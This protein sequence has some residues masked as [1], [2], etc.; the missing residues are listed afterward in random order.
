MEENLNNPVETEPAQ[1]PPAAPAAPWQGNYTPP[2][3]LVFPM[4]RK[5]LLFA[6]GILI[7]SMMLCNSLYCGGVNLGVGVAVLGLLG[8]S[9]VYLLSCGHKPDRYTGCMLILCAVI[10]ASFPRSDDGSMKFLMIC[11][12]L[13]VPGLAFC[14][15][16]GQNLRKPDGVASLLDSPRSLFVLGMGRMAESARGIKEA[17][18]ASGT[19]GRTG[20]AVIL[21]VCL[22]VPVVAILI[23]LLIS[24][25]AAFEGL[26]D[27]LPETDWTEIVN[28]VLWGVCIAYVLYTRGTALQHLPK[29]EAEAKARKGLNSITV[30][31]VLIAVAFV[32]VVYLAS[33]LAYFVGGFSGI[34]P[35]EYTMAEY[36][37]RGFFE[38][39]WLCAI[40]L[41]VMAFAMGLVT[42]KG[43]APL[44]TKF[45]CLFLGA[46]TLFLVATASA[47]MV[48]YIGSY[49]LTRLRVLTEVF[50]V[51]L[52]GTTVAVCVWLFRPKLPYMKCAMVL[53]LALCAVL[54]WADVDSQVAKYN[55]RAY[56]SGKLETVDVW[57]LRWLNDSAVPYIEELLDDADKEVANKARVVLVGMAVSDETDIRGWNYPNMRAREIVES[58]Q[59][60]EAA[61]G[62]ALITP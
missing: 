9:F 6:L 7:F 60:T 22:A 50:M 51:W 44:L 42:A 2:P 14:L 41:S 23:P 13:T 35:E 40:N 39:G 21:G 3:K 49:G 26:L 19:I 29:K 58:Y 31:T 52:A 37:R 10:A 20:G 36:A 30:N 46:V 1:V 18:S 24:A 61:E 38:M 5:E 55:V 17:C 11:L 28:T 56:Q 12:L 54:M 34:L 16:A 59:K 15:M 32:Y 33:Q 45:L 57:Y 25:D 53:A 62:S 48:L 4:G 43:K 8:C 27:L 47:K